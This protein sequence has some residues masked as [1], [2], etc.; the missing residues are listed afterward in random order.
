MKKVK[1]YSQQKDI[2]RQNLKPGKQAK[3]NKYIDLIGIGI[4]ILL[5]IVIYSNSFTCSFHFD[6]IFVIV[7]NPNIHDLSNIKAWWNDVPSRPL[8]SL[9]FALNYHFSQLDVRS[10]H[11]VNLFIHLINSC[12][13]GWFAL[14]IFST[15]V[16]K[17]K[18][19]AQYKRSIAFVTALLFVSHPL[20]TQSV[21]Y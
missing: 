8:G 20:A 19:I 2:G 9:T 10:Y 6:D 11:V 15:P 3:Q 16:M 17:E 21:T 13:T 5:G 7:N 4:I 12:L 1:K 18:P 14:L